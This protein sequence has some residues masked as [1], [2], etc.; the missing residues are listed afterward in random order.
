MEPFDPELSQLDE[1]WRLVE[2]MLPLGWMEKARELRAFQRAR[3]IEDPRALLRVMLIHLAEGRG[4]RE[5]AAQAALAGIA[6]VS[7]V[8]LLKR[9]RSCGPW[10]EWIAQGMREAPELSGAATSPL[11]QLLGGR[12]LRVV[13]GSVV[14]EPGVTGSKWRLHYSISLPQLQCQE[15]HLGPS[16]DGETLRRFQVQAGDVFMADRGYAQPAGV[17]YVRH[18]GGDVIVRMNLVTLPLLEP[19]AGERLDILKCVRRLKIGQAGSWPADVP[20]KTKPGG[21]NRETVRGRLCAIRKS[22]TAAEKSR[23]RVRRESQRNGT[24]LQPQT[25]EA[26]GYVFVFT[27]LPDEISAEEILSLYR[28][29][30]QIEL[31]FKRLESL[32]Q[33]GHLKKHDPEAARSWLQGKLMVALIIARLIAHAERVSPWGYEI[34]TLTSVARAMPVA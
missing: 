2:A 21:P 17:A 7:D 27:T 16:D 14:S 22:T 3:G 26:A 31:E 11:S 32:I 33:L 5:T 30:W 18:H 1:D 34:S 10:F 4:L 8:A 28:M 13:D 9:L 15:V 29:R 25:L 6:D 24:Q 20:V 19:Q 23:Q 12:R